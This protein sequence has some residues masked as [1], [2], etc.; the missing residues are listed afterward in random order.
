MDLSKGRA[1]ILL[2]MVQYMRV[3]GPITRL[4]DTENR[5]MQMAKFITV[6]GL[7]ITWRVMEFTSM[8]TKWNTMVYSK[9][10]R[11]KALGS[12]NGQMVESMLDGGSMADST[13]T[14]FILETNRMRSMGFGSMANV[15]L[16]SMIARSSR[17]SKGTLITGHYLNRRTLTAQKTFSWGMLSMLQMA[18]SKALMRFK[19]C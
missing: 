14:V 6:S 9:T 7:I 2:R 18:G 4:R 11:N 13:G 3:I 19:V 5:R 15:L 10:T 12:T 16:G 8:L 17:L 1:N